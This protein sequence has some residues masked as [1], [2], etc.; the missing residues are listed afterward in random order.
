MKITA[1]EFLDN[2]NKAITLLG[3]SGVGKTTLANKLPKSKWFHYSGDY[4]IGTKYLA[5]P[6]LD[7]IKKQAMEVGF[8]RDLLRSDSIY[9]ASNITVDNLSPVS[10]FL[11]KVGDANLGGINLKEFKKRQALHREAEIGAMKD[12]VRFLDMAKKIYGYDHFINDAGGSICEI[13]EDIS[14]TLSEHTVILYL[15]ANKDMEEK[16]IERA[17][18]NPKPMYF[19]ETF[20]D[21]ELK[22]YLIKNKI[23]DPNEINPDDFSRWVF[24]QLI[25]YRKPIYEKFSNKYGYTIDANE[26]SKVSN[27]KE[28]IELISSALD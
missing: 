28:L 17:K 6:I 16:I 5:E 22:N 26:A 11:G 15:K 2:P 3:M 20:L 10:S 7:N 27:E 14:K 13:D 19:N 4:R 8:L 12:V 25:K 18:K 1:K 9:I 23:N 21:S 24:P